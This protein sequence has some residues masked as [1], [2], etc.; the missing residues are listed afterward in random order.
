MTRESI[1]LFSPCFLN[2]LACIR[3]FKDPIL[4]VNKDKGKR[5]VL[6]GNVQGLFVSQREQCRG[7]GI[8]FCRVFRK[9]GYALRA[10]FRIAGVEIDDVVVV[11]AFVN[12]VVGI[13]AARCNAAGLDDAESNQGFVL[14][15][16]RIFYS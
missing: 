16:V 12:K 10:L 5:R 15:R 13:V 6:F 1:Q 9:H 7:V 8:G 2:K 4:L 3:A 11:C 14:F